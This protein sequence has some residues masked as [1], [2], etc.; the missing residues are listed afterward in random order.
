MVRVR[1]DVSS[2]FLTALLLALPLVAQQDVRIEVIGELISKP[3]VEIT[4]ALLARFGIQVQR[5]GW[6]AFRSRRQPLR[7]PGEVFVEGDASS[8]SYFVG[9]WRDR[10]HRHA[11]PH[12]RRGQRIAARRRPLCR[13]RHRHGRR[14]HHGPQLAGSE[15]R[16]AAAWHH[17]GL[18]PHPDAA[19]TLSVMA[20]YATPHHADQY[21]QLARQ[22]TDRIVA[23]ATELRKLGATVEEGP[24]WLRVEPLKATGKRPASTPT[25]TTV[26][27]C[28]SRW[29]PFNGLVTE[30]AVPV[31]ILEPHC[32]AK[33]FPT[34]SRHCSASSQPAAKT[35]PC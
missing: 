25:T 12:R 11:D 16:P 33:T 4:L 10:R 23:M 19:M 28:A 7:S 14:R 1:G 5:E 9:A 34:T 18:Q 22:E 26:S 13:G 27:P 21:R 2:Q 24:D 29:P 20:L 8:A 30:A 3:Y 15:A 32:V 6:Q 17:A 31:R 35:C